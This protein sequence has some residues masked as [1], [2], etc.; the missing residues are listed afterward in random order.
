[1]LTGANRIR[2]FLGS[3]DFQVSRSF[4]RS[5]GFKEL[6]ISTQMSAFC[7]NSVWFYLQSAY[8]KDWVDNTMVFLEVDDIDLQH[9]VITESGLVDQY[10]G[11]RLS[12]IQVNDW[13]REFFLHD[14]AGN[15][16]HIG[17]FA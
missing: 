10:E 5:L 6:V 4:Y 16:L 15:L 13:G 7:L 11:V 14:P 1:M 2:P 8:V 3:A 17:T 12:N 9:R